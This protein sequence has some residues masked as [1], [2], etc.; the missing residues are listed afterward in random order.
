ML[1]ITIH[2]KNISTERPPRDLG[3][4]DYVV[5]TRSHRGEPRNL[6][7]SLK[8]KCGRAVKPARRVSARDIPARVHA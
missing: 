8:K 5:T 4:Y 3:G 7:R 1:N 6:K 2:I